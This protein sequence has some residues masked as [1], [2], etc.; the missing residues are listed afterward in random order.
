MSNVSMATQPGARFNRLVVLAVF[1]AK[2]AVQCDCGESKQVA[3]KDLF[4][5]RT[6]SC[7][8]LQRELTAE[9]SRQRNAV[10]VDTVSGRLTVVRMIAPALGRTQCEV[11]CTCGSTLIVEA[12]QLRDKGSCGCLRRKKTRA[13]KRPRNTHGHTTGGA[14]S[15]EYSSWTQMKVR[16][17]NRNYLHFDYYGGRGIVVCDRWLEPDGFANFLTDM[18]PRPAG[19]SLDRYPNKNGN[20]EPGNCRWAT[21]KEQAQNR[22]PRRARLA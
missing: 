3:A 14:V 16:C 9:R 17:Y 22:N 7:G 8:C 19:K 4:H 6:G 18:G 21:A 2:R 11:V 1:G 13:P 10:S 20:Y 12:H 15:R 5:G